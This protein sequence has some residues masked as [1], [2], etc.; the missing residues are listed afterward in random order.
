M[1]TLSFFFFNDT[2]TTEIY[3]YLHTL[4]LHDALPIYRRLQAR[5]PAAR[6]GDRK[7]DAALRAYPARTLQGLQR[8]RLRLERRHVLHRPGADRAARSDGPPLP[9][10]RRRAARLPGRHGA[11]PERH[12]ARPRGSTPLRRSAEH[13]S[14]LQSLMRLLYAASCLQTQT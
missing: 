2:A 7:G 10:A 8:S 4:S 5:D 12:R 6:S 13:T 11:E 1:V 14:E 3:T 9:P